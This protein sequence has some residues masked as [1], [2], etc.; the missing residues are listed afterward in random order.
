MS[1]K[2]PKYLI[3]RK[4]GVTFPWNDRMARLD[5]M[6][7]T[8]KKPKPPENNK[9]GLPKARFPLPPEEREKE[10]EAEAK[11]QAEAEKK[12]AEAEKKAKEEAELAGEDSLKAAYKKISGEQSKA[13]VI[14]VAREELGVTIQL[15]DEDGKER[16]LVD[17]KNE[18]IKVLNERHG[19]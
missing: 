11:A 5:H 7:P 6:E 14:E 9:S 1:K 17:I 13:G 19:K 18:A 4:T 2:N 12:A 16:K 3:N 8:D 10:K 15:E